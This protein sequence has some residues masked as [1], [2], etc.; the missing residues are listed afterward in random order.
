MKL[1]VIIPVYNCD[2]CLERCLKSALGQQL[3]SDSVEVIIIDDGSTDNSGAIAD[4]YADKFDN[5][6]VFHQ[7]NQGVSAARNR[8]IEIATGD[9]IHFLDSDDF[10]LFNDSYECLFN[11]IREAGGRV[12][13]L[14]FSMVRLFDPDKE[15]LSDYYNLDKV[16]VS[17]RGTGREACENSKFDGFIGPV[18]FNAQ[19]L[20]GHDI[21]FDD[22]VL[23]AEDVNFNLRVYAHADMVVYTDACI[24]GYYCNPQSVTL[25][26]ERK[27][28][29]RLLDNVI[30]KTPDFIRLFDAYDLPD[31]KRKR[32][33][34][35]AHVIATRLLSL[36]ASYRA[37]RDYIRRGQEA[38]LFP[39]SQYG[40][41]SRFHRLLDSLMR[42]PVCFWLMSFLYRYIFNPII[43]PILLQG[44]NN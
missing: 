11:L 5:V 38:H 19:L 30:E 28:L 10:L 18:A 20:K 41:T 34:S 21:R 17:F 31:F 8:G 36:N 43:K 7:Q 25:C 2:R 29:R 37:T 44:K 26:Y 39:F 12:D 23:W 22:D 32:L 9:Y 6:R 14:C 4:G 40:A 42:H 1:S 33:L 24:Y 13:V 16:K 3:S 27:K 35:R 15:N